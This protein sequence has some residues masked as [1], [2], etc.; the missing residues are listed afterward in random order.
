MQMESCESIT[1]PNRHSEDSDGR[2]RTNRCL[3]LCRDVANDYS[4]RN[5]SEKIAHPLWL[6]FFSK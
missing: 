5:I 3:C 2:L 6:F 4:E 1:A